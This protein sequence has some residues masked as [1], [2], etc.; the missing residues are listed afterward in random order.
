MVNALIAGFLKSLKHSSM[1]FITGKHEHPYGDRLLRG[2]VDEFFIF[3][4]ALP[5]LEILVLM[6]H[7]K[8]Y[9]G[10]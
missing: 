5:R 4:C 6:H 10:K 1:F 2:T 3:G 8:L 7:C 9:F